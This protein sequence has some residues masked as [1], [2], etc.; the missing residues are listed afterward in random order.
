MAWFRVGRF[1]VTRANAN[2]HANHRLRGMGG[3][4]GGPI[5]AAGTDPR[6]K[7]QPIS[8]LTFASA[9]K[10]T[11]MTSRPDGYCAGGREGDI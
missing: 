9:A 11:W 1:W 5:M 8:T 3:P 4:L 2:H 7:Y 10:A 6:L